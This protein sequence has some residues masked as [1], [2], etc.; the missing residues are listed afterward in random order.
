[1]RDPECDSAG[2]C[3]TDCE[4]RPY[5]DCHTVARGLCFADDEWHP[6]QFA[7]LVTDASA[8]WQ[9]MLNSYPEPGCDCDVV[10]RRDV[11]SVV[12]CHPHRVA[13]RYANNC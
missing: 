6:Q 13:Q 1:M 3:Y 5:G 11:E 4:R 8:H 7:D 12:V 2:D 9:S 10:A